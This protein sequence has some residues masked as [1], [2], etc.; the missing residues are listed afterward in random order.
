MPQFEDGPYCPFMG[1][2]APQVARHALATIKG[3]SLYPNI[4]GTVYFTQVPRG[5][6]VIVKVYGLPKYAPAT[7]STPQIGPHGFH[8]HA[9]GSCV[10]GSPSKP[11][12]DMDGHW[13]PKNQPHGNHAGDFPVLFS[14]N[15]YA[16]ISFFTDKFYPSDIIGKTVAIH[17]GPDD[18]KTQPSGGSGKIIA[19]GVIK[20]VG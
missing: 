3:G 11:F 16:Q 2:R 10:E 19:C 12:A 5:T 7:A 15:G 20:A 17:L 13:N 1:L 14:N 8:I 18:Y 9:G 6:E 4:K